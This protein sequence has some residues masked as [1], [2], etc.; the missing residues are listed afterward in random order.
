MALDREGLV[1]LS[2]S[3]LITGGTGTLGHAIVRK[4]ELDGWPCDFTIFARS[5]SRLAMMKQK[6]PWIRTI[7]GDVRDYEKLLSAI[8]GHTG[9]IHAAALKRIPEC[10]HS[11][12]E[13]YLTNVVGSYNVCKAAKYLAKW[14]VGI[15]TDKACQ[16]VTTYGSS[17]LMMES[18]FR[19]Y[20][21]ENDTRVMSGGTRY[22]LVRYGN[23]VASTGSVIPLWQSQ[24]ERELPLSITD[25]AMSR[26]W[27][28]PFDAVKVIKDAI[29]NTNIDAGGIFVPKISSCTMVSIASHL[30]PGCRFDPIGLRSNEKLHEYLVSDDEVSIE[31]PNYYIVGARGGRGRTYTSNNAKILSMRDFDAMLEDAKILEEL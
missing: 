26:F 12:M 23:V 14:V 17:K 19:K 21:L 28:S 10:E 30:F 3:V 29:I 5:E 20:A 16:A 27:M 9:V 8:A 4:A 2:G 11:P 1:S 6:F 18:I 15:S 25:V 24:H 31:Y 13:C 7:I 22:I